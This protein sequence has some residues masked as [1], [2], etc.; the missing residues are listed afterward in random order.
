[1]LALALVISVVGNIF[2]YRSNVKS[3][4]AFKSTVDTLS[5]AKN[6]IESEL[7]QTYSELDKF[8]GQNE[9]LDSL[10]SEARDSLDQQRSRINSLL[11]SNLDQKS[12]NSK[13]QAE[14]AELKVLRDQYLDKI[15]SLMLANKKLEEEKMQLSGELESVSRNLESTVNTASVLRAEYIRVTAMKKRGSDKYSETAMAKRTNKLDIYFQVMDNKIAKAG[16]K[17]IILRIVEPGGQVV[18]NKGT[19]SS[20]FRPTGATEDLLYTSSQTLSYNNQKAEV[21]MAYEE[22]EK[23]MFKPGNYTIEVYVDGVL[24]GS[25]TFSLK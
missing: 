25:S 9:Q 8:R 3:E 11:K 18:G 19:G 6:E 24:S 23:G 22:T 10:L 7:N 1:M 5:I 4:D 15:D 21:N 12:L 16:E 14:L 17:N 20:S 2:Q 13:L